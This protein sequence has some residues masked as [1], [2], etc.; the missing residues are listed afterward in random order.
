MVLSVAPTLAHDPGPAPDLF[1]A[2]ER[3]ARWGLP[4]GIGALLV[5]RTRL[6]PWSVTVASLVLSVTLGY[7]VARIIGISIEGVGSS[8]QWLYCGIE[9]VIGIAAGA[10]L[11]RKRG[12]KSEAD[13]QP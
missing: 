13:P 2:V 11:W 7:L 12:Q 4:I 6:R 8:R 1:E 10:F 5:G 9:V 3:H